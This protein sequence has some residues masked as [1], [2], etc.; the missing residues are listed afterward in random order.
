MEF[1]EEQ[2]RAQDAYFQEEEECAN[3][4][5]YLG[6]EAVDID[7]EI[8]DF[9]EELNSM[10]YVTGWSCAGHP[11]SDWWGVGFV[12]FSFSPISGDKRVWAKE[13]KAEI[14]D[15]ASRYGISNL[16]F[17]PLRRVKGRDTPLV[18]TITFSPVGC[19]ESRLWPGE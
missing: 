16:Y 14:R 19:S 15:V 1:T 12:H 11:K 13:E 2:R 18:K 5:A 3:R 4:Y 8:R 6:G 7:E 17:P 9:L 10:G